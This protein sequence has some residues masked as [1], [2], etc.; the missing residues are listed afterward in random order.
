MKI[1]IDTIKP[2]FLILPLRQ[3][4]TLKSSLNTPLRWELEGEKLGTLKEEGAN[5][6]YT[7][8]D[9]IIPGESDDILSYFKKDIVTAFKDGKY[10]SATILT[11]N[12]TSNSYKIE[13]EASNNQKLLRVYRNRKL[14]G[15]VEIPLEST[16]WYT[17]TGNGRVDPKNG[18]YY[19][20]GDNPLTTV[21]L[22]NDKSNDDFWGYS[23]I[24]VEAD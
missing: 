19:S 17:L 16:E 10:Y 23:L 1:T 15:W 9:E 2:N 18:E 4:F 7:S 3:S 12:L 24:T 11:T 13:L 22:A 20:S 21:I 6:I 8:P 5:A 14:E